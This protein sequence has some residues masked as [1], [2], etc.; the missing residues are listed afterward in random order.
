VQR[1]KS[2]GKSSGKREKREIERKRKRKKGVREKSLTLA[3]VPIFCDRTRT[4]IVHPTYS[5]V[6]R[7]ITLS[8]VTLIINFIIEINLYSLI[9]S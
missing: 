4:V 8:V 1:E 3:S 2:E 5:Q 9:R 7:L 6:N